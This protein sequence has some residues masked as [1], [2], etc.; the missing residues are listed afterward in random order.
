MTLILPMQWEDKTKTTLLQINIHISWQET[1]Y[2]RGFSDALKQRS[3]WS[4]LRQTKVGMLWRK[5]LTTDYVVQMKAFVHYHKDLEE[6]W[7]KR[8]RGRQMPKGK[9]ESTFEMSVLLVFP[10]IFRSR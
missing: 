4:N 10:C 6:L 7:K 8:M 9:K 3:F 5:L 1:N 2:Q